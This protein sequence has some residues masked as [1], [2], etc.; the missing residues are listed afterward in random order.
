MQAEKPHKMILSALFLVILLA[1]LAYSLYP[2]I[3]AFFGALIMYV[4]FRPMYTFLNTRLKIKSSLAAVLV[5]IIT[6]M[7]V[8]V[9][10]YI[11]FTIIILEIQYLTA[12][13]GD[14]SRILPL[15]GT[16]SLIA[17]QF[18]R[19]VVPTDTSLHER[20]IELAASTAGSLGAMLLSAVQSVGRRLIEFI[21][22]YFTLF[23]MFI[24]EKS[25]F[26]RS[27]QNAIPFNEKNTME[28]LREFRSMV[29][30]I[31]VSSGVI[32]VIQGGLLAITF[33]VFGLEGAFLWGFVTF[34]LSFVP[35]LGPPI[36]WI[37]AAIIQLVQQDY[38]SAAGV[39][40]GGIIISSVDNLIRPAI[41]KKVGQLHPLVSIIGIII[42]LNLFGL[43]GIIMGPLLLSYALLTTRMFHEEYL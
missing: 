6:V 38:I 27:L 31:L 36:V 22:M 42:G 12:D 26:A 41:N 35:A 13:V 21:I 43:L 34:I 4:V 14:I 17:T 8:L 5:I 30:T 1:V 16:N 23:Y 3:N 32:A 40:V 7:I 37:P 19:G 33:M 25:D 28:L 39:L 11:L 9:P 2:Y 18:I 29:K 20:T 15:L 10:L 24:G